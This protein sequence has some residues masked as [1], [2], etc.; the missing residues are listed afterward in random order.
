MQLLVFLKFTTYYASEN[1]LNK[2]LRKTEITQK[3]N[4]FNKFRNQ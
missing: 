3:Y 4:D 1:N 2:L